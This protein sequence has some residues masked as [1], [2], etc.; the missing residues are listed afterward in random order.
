[1][2]ATAADRWR[3][4][5]A[6]RG[7]RWRLF[8]STV[9]EPRSRRATDVILLVSAG[10][11]L[12]LIGAIGEPPAGFERAVLRLVG[13]V[14]DGLSGLWLLFLDLVAVLAAGLALGAVVRRRWGLV[15]DLIVALGLSVGAS[16][17]VARSVVGSWPAVWDSVRAAGPSLYF[18]P[19]RLAVPSALVMMASPH[20]SQPA[21]QVGRW[22]VLLGLIATVLIGAATPCG[23]T[24]AVLIAAVIAAAVHLV[25]GSTSGRPSLDDV[26]LALRGLRVDPRSVGVA[27]RQP[28]GVFLVDAIDQNGDPLVVKVYGRDA[29]NTQLVTT[30][31]R[32]VWYREAG[33]PT[34]PGR[35][36]QAEHEA[37]LT[38]LARQEGIHTEQVVV[39][40]AT[41]NRDV[42][43]VLRRVGQPLAAVPERWSAAL[44][45][46]LWDMVRRLHDTG[47]A[48]GQLDDGHVIVDGDR[49][50]VIDF[51]GAT[52][53]PATDGWRADEAQLLVTTV[54][55]VGE[56]EALEA[57]SHALGRDRLAAVLPFVQVPALTPRQRAQVR[58]AGLD[59]DG[60]RERAAEVAGAE[61]V[62]LQKLRRV[63]ARSVVQV[64]LLVVAFWAL[65]SG[66]AGLD[67]ADLWA[68]VREAA[69]WF[70]VVGFLLAQTTRVAQAVSTLGASPIPLPLQPVYALQLATSYIALAVPSYAARIAVNIRFFQRHGLAAGSSL[71]IGGL[72]AISQFVVQAGLLAAILL[73]TPASLELDL[74]S[75]APS[76]LVR[77]VLVLVLVGL[78]AIAVVA[79]VPRL[80]RAVVDLIRRLLIDA[81]AAARGLRSPRRLSMLFGGNLANELLFAAALG[82]FTRSLGF[83]IG[84]GELIVINVSVSLLSGLIPVPGGIGVVEGGLTFGLV[85]AGMPE[86]AAFAAV[87]MYRLS[88]F[89]LPPIWGFF[90]LRWLQRN[91]HL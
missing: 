46:E 11:G 28:A 50:G 56:D 63:T 36:Q 64:V 21:R 82:A 13:S 83:P 51:R 41:T 18:P 45:P 81:V 73:L 67:F 53:T 3:A 9:E 16:L 26:T 42:L 61:A 86:E 25:F 57:A 71:A 44:V 49:V 66:L 85:R 39:A 8:A 24:A 22:C 76:G 58:D 43:L 5:R 14:P 32:T 47:I 10:A 12:A 74:G 27:M 4:D 75:A 30:L 52:V 40:G 35:L 78:I 23:A 20:L 87:L 60:L 79:A 29:H 89:Y 72:D 38:L 59:L 69:W 62:E 91:K 80:R 34:S 48:H 84:M 90:A 55:A 68:Q 17:A 15:R 6:T 31:W 19:L 65:A 37:F 77:L 1:V 54:L 7:R 33:T 2:V 70:I 88:T